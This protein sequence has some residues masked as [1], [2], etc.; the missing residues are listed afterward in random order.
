MR[1]PVILI[2]LYLAQQR[3]ISIISILAQLD[4]AV[5]LQLRKVVRP[6]VFVYRAEYSFRYEGLDVCVDLNVQQALFA[7]LHVGDG[8]FVIRNRGEVRYVLQ[9]RGFADSL[10]RN[11]AGIA[12]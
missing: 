10:G 1:Q 9:Y 3:H 6:H 5:N 12:Y 11:V 4:I 2:S 7:G 8:A